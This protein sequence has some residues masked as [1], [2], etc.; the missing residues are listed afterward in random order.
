MVR[1][2]WCAAVCEWRGGE[3]KLVLHHE[4]GF[5]LYS[6]GSTTP[7]TGSTGSGA[8]SMLAGAGNV[9]CRLLWS[10]PFHKLRLSWDDGVRMLLLRFE[11]EADVVSDASE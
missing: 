11:G 7:G 3:C 9:G 8:G 6:S 2:P 1:F 4:D 5:L 10:H